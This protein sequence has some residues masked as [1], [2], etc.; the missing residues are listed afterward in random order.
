MVR[1]DHDEI[2]RG[3]QHDQE[4]Q[5]GSDRKVARAVKEQPPDTSG[6]V[7]ARDVGSC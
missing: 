6:E 2:T 3:P 1:C 4:Q 5:E 7:I